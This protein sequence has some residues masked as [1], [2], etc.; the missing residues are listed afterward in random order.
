MKELL[1]KALDSAF[2]LLEKQIPQTRRKVKS[3]SIYYV[4]PTDLPKFLIDNN[5][6]SACSFNWDTASIDWYVEVPITEEIKL[7]FQRTKFTRLAD[8]AIHKLLTENGYKRQGYN[9][10]INT[11]D[12]L[13]DGYQTLFDMYIYKY[14]DKI[15][16]YYSLYYAKP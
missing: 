12:S 2:E 11:F 9:S 15:V 1:I 10:N 13:Q 6:P 5:V 16:D 7:A 4:Y 14:F 3:L 8:I